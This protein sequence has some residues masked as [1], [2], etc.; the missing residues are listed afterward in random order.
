MDSCAQKG[1]RNKAVH[2]NR[3]AFPLP[4]SLFAKS[5]VQKGN[6]CAGNWT[7]FFFG[8]QKRFFQIE[9]RLH[10]AGGRFFFSASFCP[11]ILLFALKTFLLSISVLLADQIT[12]LI[13]LRNLDP[14]YDGTI[15][16]IPGFFN[17][18]LVF[19]QGAAWGILSGKILLLAAISA[20]M[21]VFLVWNGK[22]LTQNRLG[23]VATGIL[24]GGTAGNLI[25][26]LLRGY[27]IDFLDFHWPWFG[28]I[29]HF[30]AFNVADSAI[31]IGF[32]LLMLNAFLCSP[33]KR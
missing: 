12:K 27:V 4:F 3:P 21:L 11:P 25:D 32:F 29:Y 9:S 10:S 8:G 1:S 13:A 5:S 14:G 16:V 30:P 23:I 24:A 31:C 33:T 2:P 28:G 26:R 7:H 22:E 20:A 17:L 18:T 6:E 19:N 15:S